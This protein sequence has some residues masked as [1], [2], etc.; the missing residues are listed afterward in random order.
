[1]DPK[2]L[3]PHDLKVGMTA[4]FSAVIL[5]QMISAF[6]QFSGDFNPLHN[7]RDYAKSL[8]FTDQ[9]AHG[10]IQQAFVSR[11][12]G[13][14]LPGKYCFIKKLSTS[15]HKPICA[16][17]KVIV[18][19]EMTRVDAPGTSGQLTVSVMS[20]TGEVKSTSFVEVGLSGFPAVLKVSAGLGDSTSRRP[21]AV[22]RGGQ[23][24]G[25]VA[26]LGG[27]SGLAAACLQGLKES[28]FDVRTIGRRDGLD[29]QCDLSHLELSDLIAYL[30][31]HQVQDVV[32]FAAL[33]P[34]KD[35]PSEA[36]TRHLMD[37]IQVQCGPLKAIAQAVVAGRLKHLKN[38]ILIGSSWARHIQPERG[39][40]TY[41]YA[42]SV[43]S[44]YARDL[45]REL[46]KYGVSINVIAPSE[47]AVG[48]NAGMDP[49]MQKLIA[50]KIPAGRM[51]TP[52]DVTKALLVFLGQTAPVLTGQ[53]ILLTGGRVQ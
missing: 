4:E 13:M 23:S 52:D 18:K 49:R 30:D 31:E 51:T 29:F 21:L 1:M 39:F 14:Y 37:S 19:G 48:M 15:Y 12:A 41:A 47:V 34:I 25:R 43:A 20:E 35:A 10:A 38:I 17:E 40:E 26:L 16:D 32:H 24:R 45:S 8:G 2:I 5:R 22:D 36:S 28:N 33:K 46:V 53:E 27:G 9:V 6:S 3:M 11:M 7:D 50:S 44:Y 42:K